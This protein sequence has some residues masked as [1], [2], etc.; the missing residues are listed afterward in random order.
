MPFKERKQ[1]ILRIA[2]FEKKFTQE[3]LSKRSGVNRSD[4]SRI[5]NGKFIPNGTQKKA[6]A[7][8]LGMS[9]KDLFK[10]CPETWTQVEN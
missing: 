6:I 2:L 1:T 4:I 5:V 7:Q 3:V 8:V 9:V 10:D